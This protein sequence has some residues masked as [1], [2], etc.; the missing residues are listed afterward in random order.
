MA[1]LKKVNTP[2]I[3]FNSKTSSGGD[4]NGFV[5]YLLIFALILLLAFSI[6][7]IINIHK[8]SSKLAEKYTDQESSAYHVVY[9]Y[10]NSCP[11]CQ[12]FEPIFDKFKMDNMVRSNVVFRKVEKSQ[13]EAASLSNQITGYPTVVILDAST[14]NIINSQV[15]KTSYEELAMFVRQNTV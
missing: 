10:S 3:K 4:M 2:R 7:Y 6:V 11:Y 8:M 9:M 14:G 5:K 13:P 1:A 15:G 12:D